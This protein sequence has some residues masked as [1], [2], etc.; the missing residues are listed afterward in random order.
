MN[1]RNKLGAMALASILLPGCAGMGSLNGNMIPGA[2]YTGVQLPGVE[3]GQSGTKTGEAC[4]KSVMGWVATGDASINAAK[5]AGGITTVTNVDY[6]IE[7]T[8]GI[9]ATYCT[10]VKGN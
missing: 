8:L 5:Q 4:A 9:F 7:S 1:V 2:L 6:K 3:S 10:I